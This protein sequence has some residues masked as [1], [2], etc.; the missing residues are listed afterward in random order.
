M[1]AVPGVPEALEALGRE[2]PNVLLS[3]IE[4][5]GEDGYSLIRKV[6]A[7]PLERGGQTP[8]AAITSLGT[9]TDRASVLRA[10]FQYHVTKP[11]DER[12]LVTIVK[13]LAATGEAASPR[14]GVCPSLPNATLGLG[15]VTSGHPDL[16]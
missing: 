2:T 8:A 7:L 12:R 10:G 11:V 5:P 3:D 6:R 16:R 9:D 15:P 14:G 13:N 1:T 4:M